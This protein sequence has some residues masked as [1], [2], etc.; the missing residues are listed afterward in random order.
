MFGGVAFDGF[1][2]K[3]CTVIET[4]ANYGHVFNADGAYKK[5][6]MRPE[7]E[8]W[9][10]Q[11]EAQNAAVAGAHPQGSL[12]WHFMQAICYEVALQLGIPPEH[13]RLTPYMQ[14]E[15]L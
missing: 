8:A 11:F 7:I 12:E 14:G 5:E 10:V 13:A 9:P 6:F 2:R 3:K 4:K 1:W 15:V